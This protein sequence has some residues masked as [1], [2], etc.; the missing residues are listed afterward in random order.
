[1]KK[2]LQLSDKVLA[3]GV[4]SLFLASAIML[5]WLRVNFQG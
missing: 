3:M 4:A 5:I 2:R 1:M